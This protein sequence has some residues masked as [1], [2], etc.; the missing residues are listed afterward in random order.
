MLSEVS[1][2][3][4]LVASS[5]NECGAGSQSTYNPP[6]V[7]RRGAAGVPKI[8]GLILLLQSLESKGE[9]GE[10]EV[11]KLVRSGHHAKRARL[12]RRVPQLTVKVSTAA[13]FRLSCRASTWI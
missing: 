1:T 2:G 5:C 13:D 7:C 12:A 9:V 10:V 4:Q 11:M 6:L 8:S 3:A